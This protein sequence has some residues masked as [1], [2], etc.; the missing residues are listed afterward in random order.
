[1]TATAH[2]QED[3]RVLAAIKSGDKQ[4]F[5]NLYDKYSG[6]LYGVC[7]RFLRDEELAQD[8]LQTAMVKAWRKIDT[9]NPDKATLYTWLLNITRNS[10]LDKLR[11]EK[12]RP[13]IQDIQES[14]SVIDYSEKAKENKLNTDTIGLKEAVDKLTPEQK[15]LIDAAYFGGFTQQELSEKFDLP[16]GT[17]KSRMR[18]AL[19]HLRKLFD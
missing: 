18:S 7:L 4:A 13:E 19:K 2:H 9:Y 16:L 6:A 5:G 3:R 15:E 14:V 8:V 1:M 11:S 12:R 17:V 10:C